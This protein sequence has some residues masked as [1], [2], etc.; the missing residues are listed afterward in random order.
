[1]RYL[2]KLHLVNWHYIQYRTI[3]LSK[4]INFIT[5]ETGAGKSTIL[6]AL[7]LIILGDM[8]GHYFNKAANENS[9][10]KLIE[11]LRGMIQDNNDE[12]KKCLRDNIDF[13]SYIVI[14][15]LN[16]ERKEVFCLGVVFEVRKE[17]NDYD[18]MFF[19]LKGPLPETGFIKHNTPLSIKNIK[20]EYGSLLKPHSTEEYN[21]HFLH[22]YMGKLKN[23]FFDVFKKS[24]AFKPPA[25]IEQFIQEFICDDIKIDVEAMVTP[26]RIYKKIEKEAEGVEDQIKSLQVISK[27]YEKLEDI[28][29]QY[30]ISKF[31]YDKSE[32]ELENIKYI[33]LQEEISDAKQF[34]EIESTRME[35]AE[36]KVK[37]L[38]EEIA[39]LMDKIQNSQEVVLCKEIEDLT[40]KIT[41]FKSIQNSFTAEAIRFERWITCLQY[42]ES[43][44]DN[45]DIDLEYYVKEISQMKLC[46]LHKESFLELNRKLSDISQIIT[47]KYTNVATQLSKYNDDRKSIKEELDRLIEGIVYPR[48]TGDL[49]DILERSLSETYGINAKVEIVADLIEVKDKEWIDALEGYMNWQKFYLIIEP[50]YYQEAIN[51]YKRL[52][53]RQFYDAGIVDVEKISEDKYIVVKNSLAEEIVTDNKYART[54]IDYLLGRVIKCDDINDIRKHK[55]A[56]TK[57]CFL[58][59]GYIARRLHPDLYLKNRCIGAESRK[60][61]IQGL[62]TALTNLELQIAELGEV[63]NKLGSFINLKV[64]SKEEVTVR[65]IEQDKINEISI[66]EG[67]KQEKEIELSKVDLFYVERL[68]ETYGQRISEK[69]Q[70]EQLAKKLNNEIIKKEYIIEEGIKKVIDQQEKQQ[71]LERKLYEN[72]NSG[73]RDNSGEK[74][75][76]DVVDRFKNYYA[77]LTTYK[78]KYEAL[79]KNKTTQFQN[80]TKQRREYCIKNSLTWDTHAEDNEKYIG[81]LNLLVETKLPEYIEKINIQK[82]KAYTAFKT[83]LLSRLKDAIDKTEEQVTFINRS[84]EKMRFGEK[85]YK[86]IVRPKGKY[87]DFYNML[88]NEFLGMDLTASIFEKQYK[89]Q[90]EFLFNLIVNT[91]ENITGSDMEQLR[92]QI[93]IYTD[94]KTYLEFDMEQIIG[95]DKSDLSKILRKNSGG[96]TQSPFFIA[97]LAAFA[98]HYRI[99]NSKDNNT[100]RL[101]IFDEA[102]S[103]MDEEHDMISIELLRKLGFQAII[104]APDD[105]IPVIGPCVDKILYVKNENKRRIAIAEFEDKEIEKLINGGL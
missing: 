34:I 23:S 85:R 4:G 86:F 44:N 99:Y 20:E 76:K 18:H 24:V 43:M 52:D 7:Q 2:T 14:E 42:L 12:G 38:V 15:V 68:R 81:Q 102:F 60:L 98:N 94:Y 51:I 95:T 25:S 105:K 65:L 50:Q 58:Y 87:I 45:L 71:D 37:S 10:R 21:E 82:A 29:E 66:L 1:M 39:T 77:I 33:K 83:D 73:W 88:K 22:E 103:K 13:N 6:D 48:S 92:K 19:R 40:I 54:Y 63:K 84:L 96:E 8:R 55:T 36:N 3:D 67:K 32:L 5:G 100:M 91:T 78:E 59:K 31:I 17:T 79:D 89:D 62:T 72:F 49:K 35:D 90:I 56:I 41:E 16:T 26:I 101:I 61:R 47:D 11:Y 69:E 75:F 64:Y 97:V 104:S 30:K 53:K 74:Y 57:D 80:V 28:R 93:D 9:Q 27:E 70:L 46:N